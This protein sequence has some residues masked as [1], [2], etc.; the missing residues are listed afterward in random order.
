[1][2]ANTAKTYQKLAAMKD[3]RDGTMMQK[4]RTIISLMLS[5]H[6]LTRAV[7]NKLP[8]DFR[9]FQTLLETCGLNISSQSY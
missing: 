5:A 8:Q 6:Y 9:D 7:F 4:N 2:L 3:Y 1:M